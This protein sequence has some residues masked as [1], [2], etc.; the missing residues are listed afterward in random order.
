METIILTMTQYYKQT[1]K[2][3][4]EAIFWDD[5]KSIDKPMPEVIN[6]EFYSIPAEEVLQ[7]LYYNRQLIQLTVDSDLF[8]LDEFKKL[9]VVLPDLQELNLFGLFYV[10]MGL[11][12]TISEAFDWIVNSAV[13]VVRLDKNYEKLF[14][15]QVEKLERAGINVEYV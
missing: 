14:T 3:E 2:N 8:G 10:A 1:E 12:G 5:N 13:N 4:L 9:F 11:Y 6:M 7:V 15:T